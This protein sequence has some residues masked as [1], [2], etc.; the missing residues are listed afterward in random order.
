M[1]GKIVQHK[2]NVEFDSEPPPRPSK[3]RDGLF[4]VPE[5]T[6]IPENF[7]YLGTPCTFRHSNSLVTKF[8]LIK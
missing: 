5:I 3:R 7:L 6:G 4:I 1:I 2:N 8:K